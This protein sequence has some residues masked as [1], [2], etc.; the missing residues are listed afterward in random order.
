MRTFERGQQMFKTLARHAVVAA[1]VGSTL[2]APVTAAQA[3][4]SED[5][6]SVVSV[7]TTPCP[8]P[9]RGYVLDFWYGNPPRHAFTLRLCYT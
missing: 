6:S 1:I 8:Y 2:V 5:G 9:S 3:T 4:T 7:T